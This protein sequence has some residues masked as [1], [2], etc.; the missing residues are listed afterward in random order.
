MT[1][2][3]ATYRALAHPARLQLL[4]LLTGAAM[5]AAEAARETGMSQANT[6]YHLR[7]LERVG[8]LQVAEQVTIR[9]GRARRY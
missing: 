3:L 2:R 9:G 4:S 7:L 1:D 8:L 5:S 6:S